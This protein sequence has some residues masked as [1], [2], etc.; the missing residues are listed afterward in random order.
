[1]IFTEEQSAFQ[2]IAR[3]FAQERLAPGYMAREQA[4]VLDRALVR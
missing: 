4:A 3:R 1:M 2:D